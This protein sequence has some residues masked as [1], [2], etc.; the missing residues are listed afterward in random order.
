MRYAS[1]G[2][3]QIIARTVSPTHG[4]ERTRSRGHGVQRLWF[5]A[6]CVWDLSAG[7]TGAGDTDLFT[8]LLRQ[9]SRDSFKRGAGAGDCCAQLHAKCETAGAECPGARYGHWALIGMRER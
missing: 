8:N 7:G 1:A 6:G 3:P 5:D 2:T 9:I 4:Q